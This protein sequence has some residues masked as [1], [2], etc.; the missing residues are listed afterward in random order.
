VFGADNTYRIGGDEYVAF[1]E[2]ADKSAMADM[3]AKAMRW[4]TM[5]KR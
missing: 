2:H 1:I 4:L 3:T 5:K